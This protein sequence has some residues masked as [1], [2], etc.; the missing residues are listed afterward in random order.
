MEIDKYTVEW[1]DE[2][3]TL[4]VEIEVNGVW[5]QGFLNEVTNE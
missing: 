5:Y 2:P 4:N 1:L 3:K